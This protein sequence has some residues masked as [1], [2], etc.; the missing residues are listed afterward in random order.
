MLE[1][2]FSGEILAGGLLV[3][4][5]ALRRPGASGRGEEASASVLVPWSEN[6]TLSN[7]SNSST[8]PSPGTCSQSA[9]AARPAGVIE[10][11]VRGRRPIVSLAATA[12]RASTSFFG[13][14]Y[15]LLVARGQIRPRL[16]SICLVSS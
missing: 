12:R 13:S 14:S 2:A 8:G 15:S 4:G 5:V 7:C 6:Q 9:S 16:R 1:R 10:Y 3:L 11:T